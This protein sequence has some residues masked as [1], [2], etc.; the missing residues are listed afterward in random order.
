MNRYQEISD[1]FDR[2]RQQI[3]QLEDEYKDQI[4][5]EVYSKRKLQLIEK[6][7]SLKRKAMEIGTVGTVC[8]IQGK[9]RR[10]QVKN[11]RL[12]TIER[13]NL[14]FVNVSEEEATKLVQ[15]HVKNAIQYTIR[16]IRPGVI[17]NTS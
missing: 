9:R 11:P 5:G 3:S 16:F 13:F 6:A 1:D 10:P 15:L 12:L 7:E 4:K 8:H 17:I 2:I 14:Y